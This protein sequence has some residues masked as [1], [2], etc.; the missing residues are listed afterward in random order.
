MDKLKTFS[1]LAHIGTVPVLWAK[2]E[3]ILDA[4]N[5]AIFH[6][7]GGHTVEPEVPMESL[8][9]KVRFMRRAHSQLPKLA[10]IKEQAATLLDEVQ[11]L[12]Q[13]RHDIVHGIAKEFPTG[14]IL[15]VTVS[16]RDKQAPRGFSL[17]E[18]T[19]SPPD[20]QN[21]SREI[22]KL[23]YLAESHFQAVLAAVM[24]EGTED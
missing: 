19:F 1:L 21:F 3:G 15:E 17:R 20:L 24:P 22:I 9:R 8:N 23:L 2:L 14:D 13:K 5:Q 11:I 6:F 16:R 4:T 10:P 12:K 18:A 7:G